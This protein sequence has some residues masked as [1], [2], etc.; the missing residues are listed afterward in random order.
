[1]H[2]RKLCV[3]PYCFPEL[4]TEENDI[5]EHIVNNCG[6]LRFLDKLLERL[7]R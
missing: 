1:M 6:K 7:L 4:D 2:L 3:H 5:G